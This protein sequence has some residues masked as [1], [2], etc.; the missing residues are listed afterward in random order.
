MKKCLSIVTVCFNSDRTIRKCIDSVIPQLTDE[1]EYLFI[2]GKST[3]KTL[4]IINEYAQYGVRVISEIDSGIYD[5]MNK[6]I[7]NASGEWIWFINSDDSI[8]DGLV[9][10]ILSAI[11]KYPNAGCLY[12]NMEYVR[13][14]NGKHYLE[15]KVAPDS[16]EGL[17]NEMV[18]GHPSSVCRVDLLRSLGGFDTSFRVAADWDLLLRMY[19]AGYSMK[20]INQSFSRFYCGGASSK[21]HNRERHLVR[22]KNKSY[23]LIDFYWIRDEIK[24]LV[25][26]SPFGI[27]N[28]KKKIASSK[29]VE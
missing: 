8:N 26:K 10:S 27:I 29:E 9:N 25:L 28:E 13:I 17:K 12:G 7:K 16:L 21:N 19:N 22:K 2:D 24:M 23:S 14:I 4:S 11:K 5:A 1:I 20:H 18:I 6:G 15:E 3:D